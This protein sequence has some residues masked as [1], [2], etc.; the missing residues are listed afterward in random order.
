MKILMISDVYFPR[1]N[2]VST[3]IRTFRKFLRKAGHE[4][5]LIAPDYG[6]IA[7]AETSTIRI[8]SHYLFLDPEDRILKKAEIL[9][10]EARL[11][12]EQFDLVHIQTPF[13]AH[14]AGV[15]LAQCLGVPVVET[16]HTYFEEYLFHY[17]PLLPRGLMRRLARWF[18][19]RQCNQVDAVVVPSQAMHRVLAGYGVRAP[20]SV[21]PTGLDLSE[22]ECGSRKRFCRRFGIDSERPILVYVGRVA[23]EKNIGFLLEVV[24]AVRD[25]EPDVLLVIA[26]EGP[27]RNSLERYAGRLGIR[28][29]V[30]F[31]DYLPRGRALWDCFCA[32]NAFVFASATE[33]QGLVLLEALALGI[34]VVSTAVM[35]TEDILGARQG[36]LV[37]EEAVEDFAGKVVQILHVEGLQD[38]LSLAGRRYARDWSAELMT[39]RMTALYASVAG[40]GEAP[41][42]TAQTL[43]PQD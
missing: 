27:A 5:W 2:G 22:F 18:S 25:Y 24:C 35:G 14:H 41:A 1:V 16:Y 4:T 13:I 37:A 28:G 26:G 40:A 29:N 12:V 34:P 11:T 42:S 3:S 19:R 36:V 6:T 20:L 10:L 30:L 32:G 15:W 9:G 33:T 7:E 17:I 43:Q 31:V 8:A 23:H 39:E 21:I 38:H